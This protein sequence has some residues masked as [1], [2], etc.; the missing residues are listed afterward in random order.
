M[1]KP[2]VDQVT[3]DFR[4]FKEEGGRP[5]TSRAIGQGFCNVRDALAR[6]L[7]AVGLTP[8][9][10]TIAG[11][12]ATCGAAGCFFFGG[13]L[14]H[15]AAR[16]SGQP[17]YM[18]FAA[19]FL[20]LASAFDMLDGAVAKLGKLQ[21]PIGAV[22]DSSVDRFSDLVVYLG[23][24]GH[25]VIQQNLTYS[26]LSAVALGNTF[27]ISYVKARSETLIPSCPVGYWMRGERCVALLI[28]AGAG[29]VPAVV[30]QQ[31][32]LPAFTVLRRLT[33]THQ[34]LAA[35]AAGRPAP[36]NRPAAG[37]RG[38]LKP[39]RYPRGSVPYDFVTGANILFIILAS[40]ISPLFGPLEDPLRLLVGD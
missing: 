37:W 4:R 21:T 17:P 27:L 34:V 31:A 25:F 5:G 6:G 39:W 10:L 23:L 26:M 8:N 28:A 22:L 32:I 18:L 16:A 14:S 29:T 35:E 13:S 12:L 19:G 1:Q 33:W 11:F 40:R 7:I 24:I 36:S 3:D 2:G 38:L 15:S 30:W 9:M 20:F